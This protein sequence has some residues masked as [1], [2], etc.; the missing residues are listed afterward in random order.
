MCYGVRSALCT[1]RGFIPAYAPTSIPV[2][3]PAPSQPPSLGFLVTSPPNFLGPI[4]Q[5]QYYI[6]AIR[7]E[8]RDLRVYSKK[9]N[10]ESR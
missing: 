1:V 6:V 10:R 7:L 3:G 2:N 8:E 5:W 9:K 4:R